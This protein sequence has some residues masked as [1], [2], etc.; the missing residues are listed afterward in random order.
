VAVLLVADTNV[1]VN[2]INEATHD[3]RQAGGFIESDLFEETTGVF[4]VAFSRTME[5]AGRSLEELAARGV[6]TGPARRA[7]RF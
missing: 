5:V 4:G 3:I 2:D 7:L 1:T 6:K